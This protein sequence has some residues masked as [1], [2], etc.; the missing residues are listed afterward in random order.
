M[1]P[2]SASSARIASALAKSFDNFV[3]HVEYK[4]TQQT[5]DTKL[6]AM[7]DQRVLKDNQDAKEHKE[8]RLMGKQTYD[9]LEELMKLIY[10][11]DKRIPDEKTKE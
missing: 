1:T 10:S 9:K 5:L 11:L 2:I 8:L 3:T 7:L 4:G 6:A